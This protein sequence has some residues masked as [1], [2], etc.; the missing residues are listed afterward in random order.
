VSFILL[1]RLPVLK[2][3]LDAALPHYSQ[4]YEI[5]RAPATPKDEQHLL[6]NSRAAFIHLR[7]GARGEGMFIVI[8]FNA[9]S[10]NIGIVIL[11]AVLSPGGA[12]RRAPQAT[13][14]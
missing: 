2:Q 5:Y 3:H 11:V 8:K 9:R 13:P 1:H 12:Q 6:S 14:L 4:R 7:V 10:A